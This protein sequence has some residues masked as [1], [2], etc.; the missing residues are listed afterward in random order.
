MFRGESGKKT[1]KLKPLFKAVGAGL[2]Q[3]RPQPSFSERIARLVS[4]S[5]VASKFVPWHSLIE[6][7][8]V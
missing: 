7:S 3:K 6:E 5:K 4:R 2:S 1:G 8:R